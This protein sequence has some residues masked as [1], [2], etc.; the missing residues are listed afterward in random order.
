MMNCFIL[1]GGLFLLWINAGLSS[2][3]PSSAE[4]YGGLEKHHYVTV[5]FPYD[6]H[7]LDESMQSFFRFLNLSPATKNRL[8]TS[9]SSKH[10]RGDLG[11]TYR[12]K[13]EGHTYNDQKSFFHY[14]PKLKEMHAKEIEADPVLKDFIE[15]ADKIWHAAYFA[16]EKVL[17]RL[18]SYY[19][20]IQAKVLKTHTPHIVLRFL[21]YDIRTPGK[22]LAKP[23]YDAGSM[24]L[25]LAESGPGLR[26][27][28][29][30]QDLQHIA[31]HDQEA[32]F[33]LGAN[34][35]QLINP[36]ALKAGWHDV[37][38]VGAKSHDNTY[39]RWAIV[40]FIDGHDVEGAPEALTHK[41]R[42]EEKF[43]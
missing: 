43:L 31:H 6:H 11:F 4:I 13:S 17:S 3:F 20:G 2:P 7:F 10:R 38:Q 16:T 39:A 15:R 24:T 12:Q 19:P 29:C 41:W 9:L 14:H 36:G 8:R 5:P 28:S 25:A 27:G 32:V 18:E 34:I 23:H 22:Y 42:V 37:V 30:P 40:A 33:F 21:R 26:I 35:P 1:L